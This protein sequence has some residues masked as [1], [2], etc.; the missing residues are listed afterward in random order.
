MTA[1]SPAHDQPSIEPLA[2]TEL[3]AYLAE[4]RE[5]VLGE[6]RALMPTASRYRP[7]LYDLMLEYPLR[8]AKALRPALCIAVCRALGGSLEGVLPSTAALEL[9]HNAFLIHDDVEDGSLRR[10][11][12][13]TL[14]RLH[15]VPIAVN[16]GDAMLALALEPLLANLRVLGLGKALRIL[17]VVSRMARASAEGQAMELSWMR[18]GQWD[19]AD[20]D[21]L[22]MVYKKTSWYTFVA[23]MLIGS[24]VAGAGDETLAVVRKLAAC[25]GIAFQIRDDVLNLVSDPARYGKDLEGDLREGKRTL[26]VLHAMRT[27]GASDRRRAARI[28]ERR[29][30]GRAHSA[31][32]RWLRR[33]ID[34]AG[35]IRHAERV[36]EAWATRARRHLE[37]LATHTTPSVHL[38]TLV[39]L[40]DFAV[41]REH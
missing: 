6:I 17:Q 36:A 4:C 7:I 20:P 11:D 39:R 15:G 24:I 2:T 41:C 21:Y 23:P 35:S 13:P 1:V 12:R 18:A 5:M 16:V 3:F 10:R 38:R 9:Y 32:V 33:L 19:L 8:S 34:D 28:L 26:I 37:A 27:A 22:R 25:L 31:S 14:H 30:P 29:S 40:A